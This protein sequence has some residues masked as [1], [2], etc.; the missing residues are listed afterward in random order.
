MITENQLSVDLRYERKFVADGLTLAEVLAM[1][2]LHPSA[3]RES[4]PA[5]VVNNIYLDSPG[6]NDYHDHI[7]G[8]AIRSKTRL[9]WYG[10]Q[11]GPI[12]HPVLERK[13]RRGLASA[14]EAY[15]L[16]ALSLTGKS[17]HKEK[18]AAGVPPCEALRAVN[19]R[20]SP[21][22]PRPRKRGPRATA[23]APPAWPGPGA[24]AAR[25]NHGP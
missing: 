19:L 13:L 11:T 16:A 25:R 21:P 2:R 10:P 1:V 8:A 22:G 6:R 14:K 5:R 12:E 18:H 15:T 23:A 24:G 3:L 9:R 20:D 7:N 4:Y 17:V